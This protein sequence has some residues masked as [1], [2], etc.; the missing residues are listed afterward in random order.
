VVLSG[1]IVPEHTDICAQDFQARDTAGA[2]AAEEKTWGNES[3][4][5]DPG[6]IVAAQKPPLEKKDESLA[7]EYFRISRS[8]CKDNRCKELP[9]MHEEKNQP[10]GYCGL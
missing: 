4:F 9:G 5:E 7:L 2:G 1:W 6:V 8:I 3:S 10:S